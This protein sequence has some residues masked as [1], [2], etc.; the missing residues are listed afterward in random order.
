MILVTILIG[1]KVLNRLHKRDCYISLLSIVEI[2]NFIWL[3]LKFKNFNLS[4]SKLFSFN[5][6]DKL[7][8]LKL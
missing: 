3:K 8:C 4:S 5:H 2:F 6:L 7:Y 1:M